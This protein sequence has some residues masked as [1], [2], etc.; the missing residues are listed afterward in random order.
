MEAQAVQVEAPKV[1]HGRPYVMTGAV[2]TV[3]N[4]K[5]PE[6]LYDF[7]QFCYLILFVRLSQK[8]AACGGMCRSIVLVA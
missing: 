4:W 6:Y 7:L 8:K 2:K 3:I 5:R 1:L